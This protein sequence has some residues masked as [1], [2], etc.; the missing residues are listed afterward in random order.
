MAVVSGGTVFGLN[1][2]T[3]QV[4]AL[5]DYDFEDPQPLCKVF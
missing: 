3:L 4:G 1:F 5:I 2:D